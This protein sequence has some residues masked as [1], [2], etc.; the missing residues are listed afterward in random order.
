MANIAEFELKILGKKHQINNIE[1]MMQRTHSKNYF[2]GT[3]SELEFK[4]ETLPQNGICELSVIGNCDWSIKESLRIPHTANEN[5]FKV[6]TTL[7]ALAIDGEL[8]IEGYSIEPS[9]GIAEH[10]LINGGNIIFDEKTEYHTICV[11]D[12]SSQ[13]INKFCD[14]YGIDFW[15]HQNLINKFGDLEVGGFGDW[16]FNAI[17]EYHM[18]EVP[19]KSQFIE[20][21][22]AEYEDF[23]EEMKTLKPEEI[24]AKAQEIYVK[25]NILFN[26]REYGLCEGV[27]V[28]TKTN[29]L[30]GIYN[31]W[32]KLDKSHE[33]EEILKCTNK[34]IFDIWE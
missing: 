29:V 20:R 15:N 5:T 32:E 16:N 25:D 1:K 9:R 13:L 22:E 4:K 21:L 18:M 17:A 6:P 26:I 2:T 34:E 8:I 27:N 3:L 30:N 24:I 12:S 7:D 33:N 28:L 10:F 23:I 14:T 19:V 11:H 31:K